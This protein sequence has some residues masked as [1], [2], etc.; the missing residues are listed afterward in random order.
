MKKLLYL[1]IFI[2]S[3]SVLSA[4]EKLTKEEKERREKNIQAGNPF[5]QF[6]YKAK[7][8]TLSKGKYLEFHDLDSI[9]TIGTMRWHVEKEQIVAQIVQDTLNPDAQPIGDRAGRWMSPDP[10][11]E[12][13]PD[14][15]PYTFVENNPLRLVDP[16]GMAPQDIVIL[17]ANKSSITLK[18]DLIDIKVNA[19]SLGVDFG[20]NYNLSGND[21]LSAGLDIVGIFDPTGVS[22][23]LG[24][25][26]SANEGDWLS[27]GI[28]TL[29]IIP[30][31]GDLA[32]VGKVSK[33]VK[34]IEGAIEQVTKAEKRA[35]K[36]SKVGREGQDF[37]K[38]G[39]ES[40]IDLNK[41]ENG[42]KTVCVTCKNE[43]IPATQS[44]KG[45]TPSK[46]ETQVDHIKRKRDG[47]SGT[48][49]NGQVLCR[50]CNLDKG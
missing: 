32:K 36:L 47:G 46:A 11:S 8:A 38:A 45:V 9:V 13:F 20:G 16:D 12:E 23:A 19:S 40:V 21:V 6:G 2:F 3:F 35:A 14:Y 22:D 42:G 48:P 44:K 26:M 30:Y 37:T 17:G 10:L 41:A 31:V 29:G 7:V 24:A 15:S 33:D 18:T 25:T 43:T 49:N 4:Q 5:K 34:I 39:K 27:A 50:G 1:F 28:S